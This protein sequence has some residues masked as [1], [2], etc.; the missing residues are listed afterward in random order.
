MIKQIEKNKFYVRIQPRDAVTGKRINWPSAYAKTKTEAKKLEKKM[1]QDYK[2]GLNLGDG[3]T[4]FAEA[5]QKYVNQRAT[6]ISPVTLKYW[7]ETAD[8]IKDYFGKAK[9][10]Q[11]T[12]QLISNFAHD[13]VTQRKVTVSKSSTIAKKLNHIRKFFKSIEGSTVK[14]N[15]VP[16]SALKVF[17]RQS[18]FTLP[19]EWRIFSKAELKTIQ[20]YLINDLSSTPVN[21]WNSKLAILIES[22]T[23]MRVGELQAIKFDNLIYEDDVWTLKINNAWSDYVGDFTGSLK[24]R[25]K[26]ATRTLLPIP[27]KVVG[28]IKEYQIKQDKFLKKNGMSNDSGLVFLNLHNYK[29]AMLGKP[30]SQRGFSEMLKTVCQKLNIEANG[31]RLSLYSF[32]HTIC[33]HLANTPNMSFTWAADRMGHSL[34]IFMHTYVGAD[35]S[36]NKKMN[37]LWMN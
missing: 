16:E 27:K 8:T 18:D 37:R 24:A 36:I 3:N 15:P 35:P 31:K 30:V 20:E 23:G 33:T 10:N 22:Y 25:P 21:N 12:T 17:F 34:Q 6:A 7:Q 9:I 1:W 26:G 5:F 2:S 29:S 14:K 13:Y 19:K 11:I 28:L 4:V 32:R